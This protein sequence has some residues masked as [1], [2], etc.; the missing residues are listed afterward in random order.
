[1]RFP[2]VLIC[3][4]TLLSARTSWAAGN[5]YAPGSVGYLYEDCRAVLQADRAQ[6]FIDSY[7]FNF[8]IGFGFGI[9]GANNVIP[10]IGKDDPCHADKTRLNDHL[11]GRY[12][13]A[14]LKPPPY[15]VTN[16]VMATLHLF[17]GWVDYLKETGQEAVLEHSVTTALNGMVT[18]GSFCDRIDEAVGKK[19]YNKFPAPVSKPVRAFAANPLAVRKVVMA[20]TLSYTYQQ[21]KSDA[22]QPDRFRASNCG[23]EILGYITGLNSTRW[24]Q[25]NRITA[26]DAHCAPAID[27]TYQ[28]LD[29]ASYRCHREQ[30]EPLLLALSW[31]RRNEAHFMQEDARKSN[32]FGTISLALP[33]L[34]LCKGL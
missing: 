20:R 16:P 34:R 10:R 23:A 12:C 8:G 31:L 30:T 26:H 29:L 7:C 13:A 14:A 24:I 28:S 3:I 21:C 5:T 17:F 32:R 19:T 33:S 9:F 22:A 6:D 25:D 18:P 15:A 2:V 27:R 1:M 4:I 11:E